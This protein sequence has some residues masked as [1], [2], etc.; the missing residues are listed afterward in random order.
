MEG[1]ETRALASQNLRPCF[2]GVSLSDQTGTSLVEVM[3]AVLV[4]LIVM[5]GGLQYFLLPQTSNAREKIKRLAISSAQRKIEA[6]IALGF[7]GIST[8]LNEVST[9]IFLANIPAKRHTSI[10]MFDDP[11]DGLGGNDVD[12]KTHDYWVIKV[13]I[14]WISGAEHEISLF[15][16]MSE[17]GR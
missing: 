12:G 15:T 8:D 2:L 3:I 4:F 13:E 11:V 10:E 6:L 16:R 9:P 5:L 17:Y 14:T 1:N 7:F